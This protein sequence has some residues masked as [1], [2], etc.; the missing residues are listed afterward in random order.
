MN[1]LSSQ[2]QRLQ[3][4]LLQEMSRAKAMEH[5]NRDLRETLE[6][7]ARLAETAEDAEALL[8]VVRIARAALSTD[9]PEGR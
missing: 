1:S 5:A 7:L 6:R 4:R 3:R 2:V 9:Q 8:D